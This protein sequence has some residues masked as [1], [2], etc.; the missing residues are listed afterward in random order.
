MSPSAS[1]LLLLLLGL[2]HALPLH[3]ERDKDRDREE[4]EHVDISTR[5]LRANKGSDEN[6]I[7]GDLVVPKHRN[8][9][10]C[11]Y[12]QC[13]WRKGPDGLVKVPYVISKDFNFYEK[14]IIQGAAN[15]FGRSTCI[16][17]VPRTNERDYI[18]IVN[19]GGCYSSLG[20]VGGV[21]ELSLNRAGCIYGGIAQHE[22][23]HALGFQH[24]QVRSDR[25]RYVKISWQNITPGSAYNFYKANTNNLNTPYDY[26]SI[27]Q[28]G[29]DAFSIAYG[30]YTI[31]PIPN[32][33][34]PIGQRMGLSSWDIKRI[35]LLYKCH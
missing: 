16:R 19:K 5:I 27:M 20:R 15:A 30:K 25:D 3:E 13:L 9:I 10:K 17:Y 14:Q 35:N 32:P 8:A 26:S 18:Y 7:E 33:N 29:R 23:N 6:L 21:Q 24:E 22:M 12:A 31:T 2:S 1:L 34:T 28:Y 4:T 11:F